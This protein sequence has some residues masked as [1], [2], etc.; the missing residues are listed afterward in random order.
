MPTNPLLASTIICA[1]DQNGAPVRIVADTT[2]DP[3]R[4]L[5]H[6]LMTGNTGLPGVY[7]EIAEYASGLLIY[8][9]WAAPGTATSSASWAIVKYTYSGTAW[10]NKQ[11]AGGAAAFNKTWDGRAGHSYS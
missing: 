3:P 1:V 11:W 4:I 6:G 9:G 7:T 5:V 2:Y 8:Q 10:T